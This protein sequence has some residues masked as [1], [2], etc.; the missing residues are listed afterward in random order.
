LPSNA[1]II[2]GNT[3]VLT[4]VEA[5]PNFFSPAYNPYAST[6][7]NYTVVSFNLSEAANVEVKIKNF[8]GITVRSF[9]KSG[10]PAGANTI[11]WDGKDF[12]AN[13]V[14]EGSYSISL[15]AIDNDGNR[16]LPRYAAII[17]H[18]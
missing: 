16:S 14:K 2:T 1:I 6:E 15:T 11:I 12:D 4:D 13:L 3:P 18:Y 10:L 8:D 9:N 5:K 7:P 17:I